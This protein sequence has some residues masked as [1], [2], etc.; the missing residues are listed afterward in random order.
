M[1]VD[2]AIKGIMTYRKLIHEENYWNNPER[3]SDVMAKLAVYNAYLADNIATFHKEVTDKQSSIFMEARKDVGVTE[4]DRLA[5]L[6][7]TTERETYEKC[8][9][10][11]TATGNLITVL[12]SRLKV[13]EQQRKDEGI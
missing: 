10:I 8:K 5:K 3:L 9:Y 6:E 4:A 11:Y 7:S 1:K 2:E 12:Q 13:I